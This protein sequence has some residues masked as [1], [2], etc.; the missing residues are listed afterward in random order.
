MTAVMFYY[1]SAHEENCW[2]GHSFKYISEYPFW[3]Y[4]LNIN[5]K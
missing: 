2:D 1:C 5:V 4:N 3:E